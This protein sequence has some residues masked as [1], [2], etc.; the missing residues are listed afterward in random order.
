MPDTTTLTISKYYI[1]FKTFCQFLTVQIKFFILY[2]E[3]Q[4][5]L[6]FTRKEV[7]FM[8]TRLFILLSC[9]IFAIF[10]LGMTFAPTSQE[11]SYNGLKL[12]DEL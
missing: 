7:F 5:H 11:I 3:M 4:I 1:V 12:G 9:L 10:S 2:I 6:Y 8:K